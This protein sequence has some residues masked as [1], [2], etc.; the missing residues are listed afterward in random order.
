MLHHVT[1]PI[2]PST[3]E[4]C[5]RFYG[6]L[7]FA[8]VAAP[9]GAAGRA[10][11]LER[12]GTQIHLMLAQDAGPERGHIGV[13]LEHYDAT[14]AELREH[15]HAV[16]P[17]EPHWGSPRAYVRDPAGHLVEVMAFRPGHGPGPC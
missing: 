1:R 6:L 17:R 8:P 11:W 14:I 5:V 3:L 16:E 4:E 10:A 7:G 15:G 12:A 9:P 2:Q 13:V